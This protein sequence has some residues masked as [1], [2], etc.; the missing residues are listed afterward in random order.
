MLKELIF[1]IEKSYRESHSFGNDNFFEII[2]DKNV[3]QKRYFGKTKKVAEI[4][5]IINQIA[6]YDSTVLITGETGTGKELVAKEIFEKSKRCDKPF[7][8]LNCSAL[9]ESLIES[10]LFG[11]E[12]GAFTGAVREKRGLVEIADGG[13]LF[14]D[15]I[16]ELSPGLQAKLLRLLEQGEY[17]RVGG[18]KEHKTNVRII[19]ATNR[20]LEEEVKNGIFRKDLYYRLNVI[21]I[22]PPPLRER[23]EDIPYMICSIISFFNNLL[24]RKVTKVSN[25]VIDLFLNYEWPGNVREL[26][27]IIENTMLTSKG[28]IIRKKDL[29]SKFLEFEKK[30]VKKSNKPLS[31]IEKEYILSVLKENKGNK[32]K[33][34]RTLGIDRTTLYNKLRE[35]GIKD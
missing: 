33:S 10:E 9:Q 30:V 13:T 22:T 25:E 27:N 1:L 5:K 16:G 6:P 17:R 20:N 24:G 3:E 12:Q 31:D 14:L 8:V 35:Y 32:L 34:A 15:E 28:E 23:R 7:V 2:S 11:H 18:T 4:L 26:E 19:A 21:N 29:P